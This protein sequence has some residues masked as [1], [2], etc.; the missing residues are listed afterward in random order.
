MDQMLAALALEMVAVEAGH[1]SRLEQQG[2]EAM[3]TSAAAAVVVVRRA[4]R[5]IQ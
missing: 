3:A 1:A 2:R 4:T 5:E